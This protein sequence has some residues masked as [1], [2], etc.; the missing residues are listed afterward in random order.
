MSVCR[1]LVRLTTRIE[2]KVERGMASRVLESEAD[3][4]EVKD[5][6]TKISARIESFLVSIL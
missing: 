1:S 6:L 3:V 4:A 5:I 2:E